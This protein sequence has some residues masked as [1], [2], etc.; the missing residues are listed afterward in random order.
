MKKNTFK[1]FVKNG[2]KKGK[3]KTLNPYFSQIWTFYTLSF[4][5][6]SGE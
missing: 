4:S 6:P 1:E 3:G 2:H 5:S